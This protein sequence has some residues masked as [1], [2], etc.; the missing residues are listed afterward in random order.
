LETFLQLRYG[1]QDGN[2]RQPVC[3]QAVLLPIKA[4]E[5]RIPITI[6]LERSRMNTS[7]QKSLFWPSF[8]A[9]CFFLI[10]T[11]LAILY[12]ISFWLGNDYE[13]LGLANAM[14]M[15]FR[16]ADFRMYPAVGMTNHPGVPFYLINWLALALAGYPLASGGLDFFHSVIANVQHYQRTAI[17]LATL[18]G[19]G[20]VYIFVRTALSLAPYGVTLAGLLVWLVSTPKS[21]MTFLS[22]SN[23][24]F[25]ILLN[26]L[27]FSIL[28]RLA[29]EEESSPRTAVLAGA[30]SA[31]AYLNKLS[32]LYIPAALVIALLVR[33][34]PA[35]KFRIRILPF[36]LFALAC[37]GV[38][39]ACAIAII[40]WNEFQA[41]L[42]FHRGVILRSGLYGT[43]SQTVVSPDEVVGALSA[44]PADRAFAIP[45]AIVGGLGLV[46]TAAFS[47]IKRPD[48]RAEATIGIASG[49]AALLAAL[50]VVKHYTANY[51]AGVSA[52]LPACVVSYY[53]LTGS[54]RRRTRLASAMLG[55]VAILS[56]AYPIIRSI[57]DD[58]ENRTRLTHLTEADL[59]E[60][61]AYTAS[62]KKVI[63]FA[64]KTP[65]AQYGEGF[66]IRYAGVQPLT[67]AYLKDRRG[68][69]NSLTEQL[70]TEDVGAYVIDKNYFRNAEAVKRAE[71]VDLLGPR[72]IQYR[73]GDK[74]VELQTVFLLIRN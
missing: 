19:A 30:V 54:W 7:L 3:C 45:I 2:H 66:V 22:P 43:G 28:T 6:Y 65:F 55:I 40:G 63:N 73:E 37:G 48:R 44:I 8:F 39:L 71:N 11:I 32:Y 38:I 60:I 35:S 21:I 67:D 53:L 62:S 18:A 17:F 23:E 31:L 69:T 72:P 47:L 56:M 68:T 74:L 59:K 61:E 70:T 46:V 41:L 24:S 34:V 36:A 49:L 26:A 12:P 4:L 9:A 50:F 10:P 16:L 51:A 25:A 29:Y 27:F 64:Y 15:A 1:F 5:Y 57:K 42:V 20:G 13:P 14:N 33:H 52:A 58:L